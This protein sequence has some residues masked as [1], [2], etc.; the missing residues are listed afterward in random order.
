M[1]HS[2]FPLFLQWLQWIH[3]NTHSTSSYSPK[4]TM[5]QVLAGW[6][7][8]SQWVDFPDRV[9]IGKQKLI[10]IVGKIPIMEELLK[11]D[12]A[13]PTTTT[14]AN[15]F[16]PPTSAYRIVCSHNKQSGTGEWE[17]KKSEKRFQATSTP[18]FQHVW[19]RWVMLH[20]WCRPPIIVMQATGATHSPQQ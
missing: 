6:L 17:R 20:H 16:L 18:E 11:S 5:R 4:H 15:A 1:A 7:D 19:C 2:H 13:S 12:S 3:E 9:W 14:T 10:R 8:D